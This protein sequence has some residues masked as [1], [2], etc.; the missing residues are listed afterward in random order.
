M[1]AEATTSCGMP[2]AP[3]QAGGIHVRGRRLG[4]KARARVKAWLEGKGKVLLC[5]PPSSLALT[6]ALLPPPEPSPSD[7]AKPSCRRP[8]LAAAMQSSGHSSEFETVDPAPL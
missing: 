7:A 3:F 5:P 8:R 4:R 2:T 1:R 6:L